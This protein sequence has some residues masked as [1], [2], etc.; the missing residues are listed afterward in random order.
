MLSVFGNSRLNK[1]LNWTKHSRLSIFRVFTGTIFFTGG[2]E[3]QVQ[4]AVEASSS[5]FLG[6]EQEAKNV[7]L[8]VK[9][10][11]DGVPGVG[12]TEWN[13]RNI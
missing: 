12:I 13:Y 2:Q 11:V 3:F 1:L 6:M 5:H 9:Y 10:Q 7:E 4:V 8:F